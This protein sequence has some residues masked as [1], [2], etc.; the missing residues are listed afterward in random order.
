M[1][2][3]R[4]QAPVGYK[5]TINRT[6]VT[7]LRSAFTDAYPEQDFQNLNVAVDYPLTE[8][9]YP[10][11]ICR[12]QEYTIPN[13]GVG[14]REYFPDPYGNLREWN[15][16]R[17]EGSMEFSIYAL[18]TLDR[19]VLSDALIEIIS[20]GTLN[21]LLNN[22]FITVY[23]AIGVNVGT[24]GLLHQISLN[25]DRITAMGESNSIAPWE[26]EDVLVYTNGYMVQCN[27]GF[28]NTPQTNAPLGLIQNV[29]ME[30][31]IEGDDPPTDD[32]PSNQWS[33]VFN[34]DDAGVVQSTAVIGGSQVITDSG[35]VV[36]TG[37][38]GG[39]DTY[40]V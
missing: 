40:H 32:D 23:G 6:V 17:Y 30:P 38:I 26:P 19:D 21:D 10:A 11:I 34:Y 15:H 27:G 14:H 5:T 35:E 31:Y 12:Y 37:V 29:I 16:R 4:T 9:E 25:T 7:A 2:V 8:I 24:L 13:A 18:S 1:A 28:Y 36:S 20:F 22:F 33:Y 39:T 3:L